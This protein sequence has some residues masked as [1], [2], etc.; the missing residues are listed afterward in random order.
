MTE[1]TAKTAEN[2]PH[3]FVG[4]P[5]ERVDGPLKVTGRATYAYEHEQGGKPDYGHILGAAI[6]SGRIVEIDATEAERAPGVIKVM[7]FRNVPAQPAFGPPVTPT[8]PEVLTRA[9][10]ML[11]TDRVRYYDEPVA[12]VVAESF[13]AARAATG[14]IRISYEEDQGAFD[15][16]GRL[17]EAYAPGRTNAGFATDSATGDFENA[18]SNAAI[19]VDTTYRTPYEH[20]NPMEPHATLAVWSGDELTIYTGAQTLAN[21][22]AGIANT[23]RVP[24]DNVRIVSPFVGGGFG[25]KLIIHPDTVLAAIAAREL[26]RPVKVA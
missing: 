10:P 12:L 11:S 3:G 5:L 23:L 26:Q 4:Q 17:D 22:Q 7:T 8:V 6:A 2:A 9:R 25:S 13:E 19:T 14:L 20:H 1:N 24:A 21:F 18:F 15:L 16:S